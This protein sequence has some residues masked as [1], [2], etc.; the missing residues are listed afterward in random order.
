[1][2]QRQAIKTHSLAQSIRV[3]FQSC[4]KHG[5]PQALHG[6]I[7]LRFV[8][9]TERSPHVRRLTTAG[10]EGRARQRQH[11]ALKRARTYHALRIPVAR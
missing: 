3:R 9:Q 7:H 4:L 10:K 2:A 5:I 11:A 8:Q 1:M 6:L